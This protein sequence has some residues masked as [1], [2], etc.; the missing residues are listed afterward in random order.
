MSRAAQSAD[1]ALF[2]S[3]CFLSSVDHLPACFRYERD[4]FV[5]RD[6]LK[7]AQR[8]HKAVRFSECEC[9]PIAAADAG[10]N[11]MAYF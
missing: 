11:G 4:H 7:D 9:D 6:R 2:G 8:V 1:A 10:K 5:A 3:Y